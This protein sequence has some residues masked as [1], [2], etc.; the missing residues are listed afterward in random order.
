MALT[1]RFAFYQFLPKSSAICCRILILFFFF[2]TFFTKNSLLFSE[3]SFSLFSDLEEVKKIDHEMRDQLPFFY[4]FNMMGGYFN[5]PSSRMAPVGRFSFGGGRIPPY[6][7]YGLN[8]QPFERLELSGNYRVYTSTPERNFG[9]EG[10]GDDAERI[11]NIKVALLLPSDGIPW[12][13]EISIGADDFIGTKR[14]HSEY[15]VA[16]KQWMNFN[17]ETSL[18]WGKGR[19]NGFFGGL[20]WSPLRNKKVFFLKNLSFIGEYDCI[21]YHNHFW[22]HDLGRHIKSRING[23]LALKGPWYQLSI[24]TI[25]GEKIGAFASLSYPLGSSQGLFPKLED[26]LKYS[27]PVDT[28][29]LGFCRPASDFAAHLAYAFSDQG[30]DLYELLVSFDDKFNKIL[31]IKVINNRYREEK[32]TRRRIESILAALTPS[33][34]YKIIVTMEVDGVV[35]QSY[36]FLS[37]YLSLYRKEKMSDAEVE[38]LFP[39]REPEFPPSPYESTL[40][41]KR[42][43]PIWTFSVHPRL[44][45]FFGSSQGKFKYSLGLIASQEGYIQDEIYYR[46]QAGYSIKSSIQNL[47][48]TDRINPSQL[49]QVRTDTIKYYQNQTL[50]LEEGYLQ[51]SAYLGKSFFARLAGGYFEPAYGGAALELLYAKVGVNWAIGLEEATLWKRRYRGFAFTHK[52]RKLDGTHLTHVPFVGIQYFA[53]FYY[54]IPSIQ[55]E[56]RFSSGQFL[57]KDKGARIQIGRYFS[58][59]VFFALWYTLTNGKDRVNGSIYHDKGF[60]FSIPFDLFLRQSSRTFIAYA[61]SAWLRDVG[62]VGYT[63]K[64]LYSSLR[65]ERFSP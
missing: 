19:M 46:L 26:P 56:I 42:K 31:W 13:P 37:K 64:S 7:N 20:A 22:E 25:R 44:L 5:M 35:S 10:F 34:I 47:G 23:G 59:G 43:K 65:E 11:G 17:L 53:N 62:A 9:S 8:F 50:S 55:T 58:S 29:P 39:M 54:Y 36:H 63:G 28:E 57:A 2:L 40:L 24:S 38:T 21:D 60:S 14:F 15:I 1:K 32:E 49:L 61:M 6:N 45:S 12:A 16:T 27:A 18:G 4:N 33:D 52:I 30:L 41:F 48:V 3:N 51:K